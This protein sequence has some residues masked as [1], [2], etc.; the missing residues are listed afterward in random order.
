MLTAGIGVGSPYSSGDEDVTACAEVRRLRVASDA[1]AANQNE[2]EL[3]AAA[4]LA[5]FLLARAGTP[6]P[7]TNCAGGCAAGCRP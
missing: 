7:G 1:R 3:V 4:R 2:A 5:G 6:S